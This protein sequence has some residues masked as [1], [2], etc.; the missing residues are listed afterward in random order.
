MASPRLDDSISSE[1]SDMVRARVVVLLTGI[2]FGASFSAPDPPLAPLPVARARAFGKNAI[3]R[4]LSR[5]TSA[6][7]M[8]LIVEVVDD[9]EESASSVLAEGPPAAECLLD[10]EADK[11][12]RI[13]CLATAPRVSEVVLVVD[14]SPVVVAAV[15]VAEVEAVVAG[16]E[17]LLLIADCCALFAFFAAAAPATSLVLCESHER[18]TL[19]TA[20][21]M[22]TCTELAEAR[23]LLTCTDGFKVSGAGLILDPCRYILTGF[24][25]PVASH[26]IIISYIPS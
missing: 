9:I 26:C 13:L 6:G 25:T 16:L 22:V 4:A 24:M 19:R 1:V 2:P 20:V 8:R 21:G 17:R 7:F 3:S 23:N 5:G 11:P 10:F 14:C 18:S 12:A 15:V